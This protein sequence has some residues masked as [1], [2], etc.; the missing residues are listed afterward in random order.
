MRIE[1]RDQASAA[2]S[3]ESPASQSDVAR[4]QAVDALLEH[5]KHAT[6]SSGRGGRTW[7]EFIHEGHAE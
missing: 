3:Q 4:A 1:L 2:Q 5:L 6:A 7:R